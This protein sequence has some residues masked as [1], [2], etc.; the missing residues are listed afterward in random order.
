MSSKEPKT[1]VNTE[2]GVPGVYRAISKVSKALSVIGVAKDAVAK[3]QNGGI[4]YNFRGIDAVLNALAPILAEEELVILPRVMSR[5][6]IERT[7][8]SGSVLFFVTVEAEFDLVYAGDGS[9]HT[10]K[11][12]G[13][14]Q[15]SGDKAT[16]KALSAAYKYMAIEVFCIPVVGTPDADEDLPVDMAPSSTASSV[17]DGSGSPSP[18]PEEKLISFDM[19]IE[20]SDRMKEGGLDPKRLLSYYSEKSGKTLTTIAELPEAFL[21][22]AVGQIDAAIERIRRGS[23]AKSGG[24]K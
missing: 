13:E 19:A 15:D 22:H 20:L 6:C 7:T 21:D 3:N 23:E 9:R 14:A 16:N 17:V 2:P 24:S 4:M 10:V 8:K 11:T 18:A 5:E 12:Y 1:A